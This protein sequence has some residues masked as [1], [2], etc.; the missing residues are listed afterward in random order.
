MQKLDTRLDQLNHRAGALPVLAELAAAHEQSTRVDEDLVLARTAVTD[1]D[2]E[3]TKADQD[4]QLVR[5]RSTRNRARLDSGQGSP[6]ELQSMQHELDTLARRQ[7]ELEDVELEIME[8]AESLRS[9]LVEKER[10]RTEL[11]E[12]LS[13]LEDQRD[14]DVRD[15]ESERTD[16]SKDRDQIAPGL[17]DDLLAL[18]EK[19]RDQHGGL[20]AAALIARRCGGCQLELN[21]ADLGR[22]RGAAEDEVLRCEECRRILV[23]TAESGL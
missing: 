2:R 12:Q 1:I 18:Y 20:G 11:D 9:D 3:I 10:K 17:G 5:D 13:R 21:Q 4:V 16:V 6:K 23:R 19:V 7:S 15:I 14:R 22:I 8:R